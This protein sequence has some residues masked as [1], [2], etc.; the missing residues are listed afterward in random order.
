M[1]ESNYELFCE[2]HKVEPDAGI[3]DKVIRSIRQKI[4]SEAYEYLYKAMMT[5]N[6]MKADY[7]YRF[8]ILGFYY[9]RSV[10]NFLS[11]DAVSQIMKLSGRVGMEAHHY[12]G[13]IRF[14][15]IEGGI[16]LA[17]FRPENNIVTIIAPHFADRFSNENFVIYD[18]A[19]KVAV[20]H[21][22]NKPWFLIHSDVFS[23]EKAGELSNEEANLQQVWNTFVTSVSIKERE[24]RSLQ[25]NLVPLRYREFM[26]EFM[27]QK[28]GVND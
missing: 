19:R 20:I 5:R 4:S 13:F 8:M 24:N 9:G 22:K 2:Y 7:V 15:E 16:L 1:G 25:Q 14:Q 17:R 3:A 23:V 27:E 28:L 6:P 18:E 26:N 21:E 11:N 10:V 12:T